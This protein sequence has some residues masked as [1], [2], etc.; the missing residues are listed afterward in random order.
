M[1]HEQQQQQQQ[2]KKI[3]KEKGTVI[4]TKEKF[5]SWRIQ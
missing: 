4:S 3:S 2:K 1:I 5:W